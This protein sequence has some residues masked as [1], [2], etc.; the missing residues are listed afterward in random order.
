MTNSAFFGH[1]FCLHIR[2]HLGKGIKIAINFFTTITSRNCMVI[3]YSFCQAARVVSEKTSF[4]C[5]TTHICKGL[6]EIPSHPWSIKIVKIEVAGFKFYIPTCTFSKVQFQIL[7]EIP[8]GSLEIHCFKRK[9]LGNGGCKL[10][11]VDLIYC[12]H[13]ITRSEV[14]ISIPKYF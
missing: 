13:I 12:D 8:F 3:D 14:I 11:Y 1:L 7:I 6:I 4:S 10:R 5:C 9:M 2:A